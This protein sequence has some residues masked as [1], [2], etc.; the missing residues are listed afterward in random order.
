MDKYDTYV[1][2]P[3]IIASS[4]RPGPLVFLAGGITGCPDWQHEARIELER[5]DGTGKPLH[6]CTILNPRRAD[7]PMADP[8]AAAEQ[9]AWEYDALRDADIV[10]FWFCKETVQPIVLFE[11]GAT[12][13]RHYY[14]DDEDES[15]TPL[16]KRW[17]G[18]KCVIGVEE[19]YARV[20]D[21]QLQVALR[22]GPWQVIHRTLEAV[23]NEVKARIWGYHDAFGRPE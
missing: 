21:V 10:L 8:M 18:D 16:E 6:P 15:D 19:G 4:A 23:L 3:H 13:E 12:M 7:F 20:Q 2:A 11:L 1:E 5:D 9:I 14:E 22:R 17:G